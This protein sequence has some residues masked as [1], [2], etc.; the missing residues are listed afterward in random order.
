M[1]EPTSAAPVEPVKP[2]KSTGLPWMIATIVLALTTLAGVVW[3]LAA[4][5]NADTQKKE[6]AAL[7]GQLASASE[8]EAALSAEDKAKIEMLKQDL[9]VDGK[10]LN[11]NAAQLRELASKYATAKANAANEKENLQAQLTA[12]KAKAAL[13]KAC[14]QALADGVAAQYASAPLTKITKAEIVANFSAAAT[15]CKPIVSVE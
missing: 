12:S 9:S 6:V 8:H 1:S 15:T 14:A 7:Q 4:S 5:K 3:G 10:D 2:K 13:A 11:A